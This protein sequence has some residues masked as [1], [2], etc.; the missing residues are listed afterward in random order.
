MKIGREGKKGMI[1]GF[2][3]GDFWVERERVERECENFNFLLVF[4]V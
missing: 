4:L 1:L 2:I 3:W